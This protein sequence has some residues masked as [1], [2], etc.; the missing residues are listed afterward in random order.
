MLHTYFSILIRFLYLYFFTY[1]RKLGG[2]TVRSKELYWFQSGVLKVEPYVEKSE[3]Q[4]A[5]EI[6]DKLTTFNL[7]SLS[8]MC[9]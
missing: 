9:T 4:S 2:K 1:F 5:E 8:Y 6:T 3:T 7:G